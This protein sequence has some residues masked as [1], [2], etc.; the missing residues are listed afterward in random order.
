MAVIRFFV[1]VIGLIMIGWGLV[2]FVVAV[3]AGAMAV[4]VS[5]PVFE[6]EPE[7]HALYDRMLDV[8]KTSETL[9]LDGEYSWGIG[10]IDLGKARF[11]LWM[12]KPNFARMEAV[13]LD[14]GTEANLILD[15]DTTWIY[16]PKGLPHL[17]NVDPVWHDEIKDVAF[18]RFYSPPGYHSLLH[19]TSDMFVDMS[20]SIFEFSTFHGYT[21][22]F[23]KSLD[24]VRGLGTEEIE[25]Q[26]CDVIEVSFLSGQRVKKYWLSREHHLPLKLEQV[27]H[28]NNDITYEENWS[29]VSIGD[30]MSDELFSWKPGEDWIEFRD[31][32]LEDGILKAGAEA[33]DFDLD[34]LEGGRF[35]LSAQRGKA[36]WLVFW[37]VGCPPCRVE[38]P[39]LEDMHRK[40]RKKGLVVIGFDCVD[41][42]EII[43]EFLDQYDTSYPTIA[44]GSDE[45]NAIFN[46]KYQRISGLSAVPLNYFIDGEGRVVKGWYGFKE[47]GDDS[48]EMI[49]KMLEEN[50]TRL[51]EAVDHLLGFVEG[52]DCVFIRNGK[53]NGPE[54][55]AKHIKRKAK[56]FRKEIWTPEDFIRLSA[57]KSE[58]SGKPY[59]VRVAGRA[60]IPCAEWL[61]EELTAYCGR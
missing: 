40:Y 21:D 26:V 29:Y 46:K 10:D 1:L 4:P 48:E 39:H 36:V 52:S 6:D 17:S 43:K 60:E 13:S 33:P 53:E 37:R 58:R 16:W 9:F 51:E 23:L 15:G 55:A 7:A 41:K 44:D 20:N 3:P 38:M 5:T 59:M 2:G 19:R 57:T 47:K 35:K 49:K 34:L 61:I 24:G 11:R 56:H 12:K 54:A 30:E 8:F 18:R 25:G 22:V 45:A 14:L 50:R 28:A 32:V 31:P 42:P 27:V